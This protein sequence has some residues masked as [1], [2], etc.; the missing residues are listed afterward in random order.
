MNPLLEAALQYAARG[1]KI[2]PLHSIR[3]GQCTCRKQAE[4]DAPGK[5]PRIKTGKGHCEFASCDPAQ[6]EQWWRKWPDANVGAATGQASGFVVIDLDGAEGVAKLVELVRQHGKLPVTLQSESG[7]V[8]GGRHL[9]YAWNASSATNSG[10]G[11]DIRGD[12]GLVV[13]PPSMHASGQ[14]Y[15][16]VDAA[17]P[18]ARGEPWLLDWFQNRDGQKVPRPAQA[19]PGF[20]PLPPWSAP[21][22][23]IAES[24]S[25]GDERAPI[26]DIVAALA[27]IPNPDLGWDAWKAILMAVWASCGGADE[28][29]AVFEPWC[30]KSRKHTSEGMQA[31]WARATA[32]PPR[33]TGFGALVLKARE[34]IEGWT[35]PSRMPREITPELPDKI[36]NA[37]GNHA[38]PEQ[39][40]QET[41]SNP[42]IKLNEQYAVI[43]NI[44]SKCLVLSW[45]NSHVAEDIKVP[46]FQTFKSF[47]E[48]YANRYVKI[49]D[50]SKQLGAYWLKWTGRKSFDG[51]DLVPNA[52][53]ILPGNYLNL[54][55]GFAVEPKAGHWNL[56]QEHIY[57]ILASGDAE[58][59]KYIFWFAAWAVQHP[60]E[61]AEVALVFRGGKGSGK[62][63]F[64]NAI[65]ALF[66]QHGLQIFNS[67]HLV[68]A[69]N[70]HLRNCLL[71]FADEAFWA[72]DK[73]GESVLKGMLTERELFIEQKGVDAMPW[74]N[75]LHVIMAANAEWAVPASHDERRY[76]V[77]DVSDKRIGDEKYFNALHAEASNGGLAAMLGALLRVELDGWHPRRIV[78]TEGLR[79]QKE[80]SLKPI[81][82]WWAAFLDDGV[83]PN[84]IAAKPNL[85]P[86]AILL[87]MVRE[88][89]PRAEINPTVLGRFLADRL[90]ERLHREEGNMWKMPPLDKARR[91]WENRYRGWV[92]R[93][94]YS[95]WKRNS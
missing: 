2:I 21:A 44:G 19:G 25:A 93:E 41:S 78:Q 79:R 69:F 86:A 62:G 92:W 52:P 7:R 71:L 37:N 23:G 22:R 88:Y 13:L 76:V 28:G 91:E 82:A 54:W 77:C 30:R 24:F 72:G 39:L 65:R 74:R 70:G 68:G 11:L 12:H 90:A 89:A 15:R 35:P 26:E 64:A 27:V 46:C 85:I 9:F 34:S 29:L 16:W 84:T 4:C 50:E 42:L 5:H 18:L 57:H 59:A 83:L 32:S 36:L 31:A 6:V 66:G 80:R 87:N 67:K 55:K 45:V 8:G 49:D 94:N 48:R 81:E 47:S 38:L 10:Q 1:W 63:T 61:R 60:G 53:A 58:L 51:I 40:T 20:G 33:Y 56:M 17:V 3:N 43:G 14:R 73:Q 95:E 75:R